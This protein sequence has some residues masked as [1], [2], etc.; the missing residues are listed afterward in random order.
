MPCSAPL[1]FDG[2]KVGCRKC[3][4]C[5]GRRINAWC[6]RAMAEKAMNPQ[7]FVVALTYNNET[8]RSRR[9]AAMFQY[10]DVQDLMRRL[11]RQIDYH[12]GKT[13]ALSYIAC[14]EK[15]DRFGRCHWHVVIFSEVDFLQIGEWHGPAGRVYGRENIIS[16]VLGDPWR[17][18]WSMWPHGFVTVQ[19]PDYGGMRYAMAYALKD[20][21]NV[22]NAEGTARQAGAEVFGTGEF[23][24]SKK[25]P[26]GARFIDAYIEECRAGGFVPPTSKIRVPECKFPWFPTG[27]LRERLL[28]GLAEV[29]AGIF[30]RT[31]AN[32]AG[33]STLLHENRENARDME[34]LNGEEGQD[35]TSDDYADEW[36]AISLGIADKAA[37]RQRGQARRA[38]GSSEAC[39]SCLRGYGETFLETVGIYS[40]AEGFYRISDAETH[41]ATGGGKDAN[42]QFRKRQ[43]DGLSKGPNSLCQL[44]GSI[45]HRFVFPASASACTFANGARAG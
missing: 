18:S 7:T 28:L 21:F 44:A 39:S 22:R 11:R 5:V 10:Q 37:A 14:G 13:S 38:C 41:V 26:I 6:S 17:R 1:T 20:Q 24:M 42:H 27:H 19:E 31:G 40:N 23:R 25:P 30:E 9:G 34:W 3:D 12:T 36:R 15:G 29:N 32:A 4:Y 45:Q 2:Q 35:E 16:P 33:W 8:E 43:R